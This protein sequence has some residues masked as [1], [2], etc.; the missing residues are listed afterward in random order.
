MKTKAILTFTIVLGL[1]TINNKIMA[2]NY[3]FPELPYAY[4][5]L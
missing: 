1:I 3:I 2:Q 5:A 4:D